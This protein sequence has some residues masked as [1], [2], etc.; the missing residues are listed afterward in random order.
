MGIAAVIFAVTYLVI[1]LQRIP[2]LHIGRPAGALLGATAM[3]ASGVLTFDEA[4]AA[5]DLDTILFLLGVMI[6]LGYLETSG[7]FE[8]V[9]RRAL[10]AAHSPRQ[11]LLAIVTTAGVL[12]ALF[13]N[14]TVCLMLTPIVLRVA[15]RLA[16]PPVPYLVALALSANVGSACTVL[17]NPQNALIGVRSAIPFGAFVS[18]LIV[19]SAAGLVLTF[20]LLAWLF[21]REIDTRPL[22]VP[23]PRERP[24]VARWMLVS[25]LAA[26]LG[27]TA[28]LAAGARP[29]AAA[30]AAAAAVILAGSMRPRVAL[31]KVDWSLLLLFGGLFVVMEGVARSGLADAVVVGIAGPLERTGLATLARLAVAITVLSQAVSNVPAVM[32]FVPGVEAL[33]LAAARPVWLALAS[34]STLAGNLTLLASIANLIVVEGARREGIEIGFGAYFRAGLP[35]TLG[36]LG[37]ACGW[38]TWLASGS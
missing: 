26:G 33:P 4:R 8:L 16:L 21:R 10:A 7:F 14:D 27:M 32:L 36:T 18:S 15:R 13:M 11:L 38:L 28:A 6:V 22:V 20:G 24:Q 1:G 12:S 17:G 5:I 34:F 29:A 9:E 19:P 30:M 2:H 31:Q 3:V 25:S 35:V 37:L 23:P